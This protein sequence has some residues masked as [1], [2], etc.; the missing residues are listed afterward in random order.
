MRPYIVTVRRIQTTLPP[1]CAA[2][3]SIPQDTDTPSSFTLPVSA[4]Y[5]SERPDLPAVDLF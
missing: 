4:R 3:N 1:H 5:D 2:V